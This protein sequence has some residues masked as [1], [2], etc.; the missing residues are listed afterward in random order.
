VRDYLLVLLFAERAW[1]VA[2]KTVDSALLLHVGSVPTVYT[3]RTRT[4]VK[5][6]TV[7][8]SCNFFR[9]LRNYNLISIVVDP[10]HLDADP[11]STYLSDLDP[12][13]DPSF[14][15]KYCL[16]ICILMSMWIWIRI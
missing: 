4:S 1:C 7:I 13:P 9:F 8:I 5:K 14:I 12:D 11:D 6:G 2:S 3:Q 10:D 16:F 15:L